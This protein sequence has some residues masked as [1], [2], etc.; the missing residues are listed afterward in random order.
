MNY[1]FAT[2]SIILAKKI[3]LMKNHTIWIDLEKEGKL[4]RQGNNTR[5]SDH[6]INDILKIKKCVNVDIL[7]R[8][9]PIGR[10]SRYEIEKAIDFGANRVMLPM[11]QTEKEVEIFLKIVNGRAKSSLLFETGA[12]FARMPIIMK[13]KEVDEVHLGINDLHKSFG[14]DFMFE[15]LA[16]GMIDIFVELAI[17]FNK[18]YGFGGITSLG[19]GLLK[20]ELVLAEQKFLGCHTTIISRD[21]QKIAFNDFENYKREIDRIEKYMNEINSNDHLLKDEIRCDIINKVN[22]IRHVI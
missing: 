15:L 1:L 11:F 2:N 21:L 7:S 6:S 12:S 10:E 22:E 9:N 3:A 14:L 4:L 20:S 18:S 17:K 8:V 5:I 19:S 13:I 16:Y